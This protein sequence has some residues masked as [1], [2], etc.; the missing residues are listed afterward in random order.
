MV[1]RVLSSDAGELFPFD[2]KAAF[3][4]QLESILDVS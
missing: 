1:R 4:N 3:G 2:P